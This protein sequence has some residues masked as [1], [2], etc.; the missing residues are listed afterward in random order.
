MPDNMWGT[1][2]RKSM[3]V[4]RFFCLDNLAFC[5]FLYSVV[6]LKYLSFNN[7][8]YELLQDA[9]DTSNLSLP[10]RFVTLLL[11][12]ILDQLQFTEQNLDET[13]IRKKCQ[14]MVKALEVLL[15]ILYCHKDENCELSPTIRFTAFC[16]CFCHSHAHI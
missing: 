2:N 12:T 16:L 8:S 15:N 9:I 1:E 7:W 11:P 13:L 3:L 14:R 10:D 4:C 5:Q 6:V